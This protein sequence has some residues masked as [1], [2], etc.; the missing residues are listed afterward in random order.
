M[1]RR[2]ELPRLTFTVRESDIGTT[3]L[4]WGAIDDPAIEQ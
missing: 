2:S 3:G 1:T 4:A